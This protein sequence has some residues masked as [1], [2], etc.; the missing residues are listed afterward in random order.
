MIE[1]IPQI[2]CAFQFNLTNLTDGGLARAMFEC[3]RTIF[4]NFF[5]AL[6]F[7]FIGAGIYV[8]ERSIGSIVTYLM[9]VG[10]FIS[11]VFGANVIAIFGLFLA[12][13]LTVIFFKAF[14]DRR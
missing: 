2:I 13:L 7:G 3:Y 14:V 5:W 12:F 6:V 9:L 11:V 8:N 10:I 1:Q 4:G